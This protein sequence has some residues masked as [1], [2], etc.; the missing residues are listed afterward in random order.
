MNE[1]QS[2]VNTRRAD[3]AG[4][5]PAQLDAF[6]SWLKERSTIAAQTASLSD[7]P[8]SNLNAWR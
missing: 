2:W 8:A 6:E 4:V 3:A 5:V 1:M 7:T